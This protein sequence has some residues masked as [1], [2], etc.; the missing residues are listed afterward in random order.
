MPRKQVATELPRPMTQLAVV[1]KGKP[2]PSEVEQILEI[3]RLALENTRS[4]IA[5]VNRKFGQ[6]RRRDPD[7]FKAMLDW[8]NNPLTEA[9]LLQMG[10]SGNRAA[11]V[12]AVK[13]ILADGVACSAFGDRPGPKPKWS[14]PP[15][16]KL[17]IS[18][19][20]HINDKGMKPEKAIRQVVDRE[21]LADDRGLRREYSKLKSA[22]VTGDALPRNLGRKSQNGTSPPV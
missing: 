3:V 4:P 18:A 6:L 10:Q 1:M 16:A 15:N 11:W 8:L 21:S 7:H 19:L 2:Q 13:S 9:Q 12:D 14:F 5:V 20:C 17:A 22:E